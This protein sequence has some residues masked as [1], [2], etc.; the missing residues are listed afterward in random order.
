[1]PANAYG[2]SIGLHHDGDGFDPEQFVAVEFDPFKN[3]FDR[4]PFDHIGIDINSVGNSANTTALANF[5]LN[6]DMT[7]YV[8][9]NS[10]TRML[11]AT[12]HFDYNPSL[13][14]VE[15]S[16]QLI[17]PVTALLPSE[18]A[19]GFSAGTGSHIELHQIMSWSFNSTLAP[20]GD[21]F[22]KGAGD[23]AKRFEYRELAIGTNNFSRV[24]GQGAFGVVYEGKLIGRDGQ[25]HQIAV[26]KI[27]GSN[28]DTE[29][30]QAELKT[31]SETRRKNLVSLMGWCSR[32][33]RNSMDFMCW[34]RPKQSTEL[35]LVYELVPNGNLD[36]H[37]NKN[38]QVLPWAMRYNIV[39]NIGSALRYLH[40]EC[41]KCILH[42]DI[43][44]SNILLDEQFNAK[45]ADFGLSRIAHGKKE[46]L[47]TTA[48]ET[49]GGGSIVNAVVLT[50]ANGT[51]AYMD[52]KCMK[53]GII[54]INCRSDVY[55]FGIVLLEIA[56]TGKSRVEVWDLYKYNPENLVA[57][58]D[59][60]LNGDFDVA[61]MRHVVVLGLWCSFPD[62]TRRPS[63]LQAME[64]LERSRALPNL[65]DY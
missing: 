45:L 13:D 46:A 61:E 36:A 37:L 43:K 22:L 27:K 15:V 17:D 6:G 14:P 4:D 51:V 5:S 34:C 26:K 64:V 10:T 28:G 8:T 49:L 11:V 33:R 40:H 42:R 53:D 55:S 2:G 62:D 35:F 38:E 57:A 50:K 54:S 47:L 12:L 52:P 24:L 39:K 31:I 7:A 30:F 19:V 20:K 32:N 63:M 16:K 60:R 44:P 9:F 1:M 59:P 21:A 3:S 18:V 25:Q 58:A 56:C 41:N 48:S 23:F 65:R 29:D